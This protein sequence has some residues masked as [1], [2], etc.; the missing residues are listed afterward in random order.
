MTGMHK[1]A[2]LSLQLLR[3]RIFVVQVNFMSFADSNGSNWQYEPGGDFGNG[4][5]LQKTAELPASTFNASGYMQAQ[6][7]S[8]TGCS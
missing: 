3:A 1:I 6:H 8:V 7:R 4:Q 2:G 5:S